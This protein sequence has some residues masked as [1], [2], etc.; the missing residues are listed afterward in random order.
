MID[1]LNASVELDVDRGLRKDIL[2][3][4]FILGVKADEVSSGSE[5]IVAAAGDEVQG[6]DLVGGAVAEGLIANSNRD[7]LG[8]V[9]VLWIVLDFDSGRELHERCNRFAIGNVHTGHDALENLPEVFPVNFDLDDRVAEGERGK[10][11]P[12]S[13]IA[14][15]NS[16][17]NASS[18]DDGE[19]YISGVVFPVG[20]HSICHEVSKQAL[21]LPAS[22][23]V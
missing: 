14:L 22:R 19:I 13:N 12:T 21:L 17:T 1:R 16:R 8:T 2:G 20:K 15:V 6:N 4:Y 3:K 9:V 18:I 11:L 7:K 10:D 23:L 5:E